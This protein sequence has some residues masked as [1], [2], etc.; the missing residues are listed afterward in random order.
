M[1]NSTCS[2]AYIASWSNVRCGLGRLVWLAHFIEGYINTCS[3]SY[4]IM[5]Q[6][7]CAH[8]FLLQFIVCLCF[9]LAASKRNW[10][11]QSRSGAWFHRSTLQRFNMPR[12][13][14]RLALVAGAG[15]LQ[16]CPMFVFCT[17]SRW[18]R[19]SS[20]KWQPVYELHKVVGRHIGFRDVRYMLLRLVTV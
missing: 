10:L 1:Q 16:G 12:S 11:P 19:N 8:L 20:S 2:I 18:L 7:T 9:Q 14:F 15:T 13:T 5:K 6:H 3:Y 4:V 17:A